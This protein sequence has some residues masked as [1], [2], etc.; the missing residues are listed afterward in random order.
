MLRYCGEGSGS[1]KD[2]LF[3]DDGQ[4]IV[5]PRLRDLCVF[6]C[7]D[8]KG[9]LKTD[10]SIV[11]FPVLQHLRVYSNCIFK[12]DT[13]F[14]GSG[15]T[16]ISLGIGLHRG[17]VDIFRKYKLFSQGA[18]PNI[19]HI[20]ATHDIKSSLALPADEFAK[21]VFGLISAA[22]QSMT[23]NGGIAYQ[24]IASIMP[25]SPYLKNIQILKCTSAILSLLEILGV[26]KYFPHMT[27]FECSFQ[28]IDSD[29]GA[30]QDKLIP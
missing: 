28:G 29:L 20:S 10:K 27:D 18:Y 16:L 2:V 5:Y 8:G 24:H 25:T 1:L 9:E 12:D 13:L 15:K 3:D 23:I 17:F 22:T 4:V 30:I 6:D 21:A 7:N 19:L 11:P 26:F 14:R